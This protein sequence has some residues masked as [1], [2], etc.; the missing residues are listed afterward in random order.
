MPPPESDTEISTVSPSKWLAIVSSPPLD[1]ASSPFFTRF[2]AAWRRSPRSISIIGT[3]GSTS[4]RTVSPCRVAT[5][6]MNSASSRTSPL[7]LRAGT[8]LAVGHVAERE[9]GEAD[10]P[11]QDHDRGPR[12]LGRREPR[13]RPVEE[14]GDAGEEEAH[15]PP[16]VVGVDGHER[17]EEVDERAITA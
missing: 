12:R 10:Q 11:H 5:G 1:S 8:S 2:S 6:R 15:P 16:E 9:C 13:R 3:F 7:T 17:E 4:T 14:A